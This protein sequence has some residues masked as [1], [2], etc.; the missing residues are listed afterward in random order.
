MRTEGFLKW[1]LDKMLNYPEIHFKTVKMFIDKFE[2]YLSD[3]EKKRFQLTL[4]L[5]REFS[6][7]QISLDDFVDKAILHNL[8]D[9]LNKI[10][11]R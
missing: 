9:N 7:K 1:I 5:I 8:T 4:Q 6:S 10:K 11:K 2:F 3:K